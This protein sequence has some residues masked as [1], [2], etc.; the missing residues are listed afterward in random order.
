MLPSPPMCELF[1]LSS[2]KP[3]RA[4][5]SLR[6]FAAHGAAPTGNVDG[7][8]V[9]FH[10][11]HEV[12]LYKGPSPR[13]TARGSPSSR[14][15]RCRRTCW[16]R[17]SAAPRKGG[18]SLANTQPFVR[19]LGGRTHLFAHNGDLRR[20]RDPRR[21]S[22]ASL[23]PRGPDRFGKAPSPACWSAWRRVAPQRPPLRPGSEAIAAFAAEM[24]P[25]GTFNFLYSDGEFVFGHGHRR[26]QA[27]GTVGPGLW[28]RH[29]HRA[30]HAGRGR[31]RRPRHRSRRGA[32]PD[33]GRA[34]TVAARQPPRRQAAGHGRWPKARSS[35]WPP[36]NL[37]RRRHNKKTPSSPTEARRRGVERHF[38]PLK[39]GRSSEKVFSATPRCA[40]LRS[41]TTG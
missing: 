24:R 36:A 13:T 26:R 31:A 38:S 17:T 8:G 35:C 28:F 30:E 21:Q 5:F 1:C 12:R 19:E 6:K 3:T 23:P 9:A 15:A 10:E 37:P 29:R 32:P 14:S 27:D 4:S 7:W 16:S 20:G 18:N 34:G 2:R 25:L 40:R 22:G 11:G 33:R 41:E 39:A